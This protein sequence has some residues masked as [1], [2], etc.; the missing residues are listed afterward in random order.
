MD[1]A[2]EPSNDSMIVALSGRL[3]Y[4]TAPDLRATLSRSI[5][6]GNTRL[7]L[8]LGRVPFIDSSGL[9]ALVGGLKQARD[10]GGD[11]RIARPL[12]EVLDILAL[13][14][15]DRILEPYPSLADALHGF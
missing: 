15:L 4:A 14:R 10:A 2:L 7:I 1:I 12:P 6:D 9:G 8:D 3:D 11:L 13:M 5:H